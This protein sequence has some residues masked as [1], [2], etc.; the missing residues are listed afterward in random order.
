METQMKIKS[1]EDS[2][3]KLNQMKDIYNS[4]ENLYG[5]FASDMMEEINCQ[6]SFC[7]DCIEN[8]KKITNH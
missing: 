4:E 6:I 8:L 1:Y 3:L 7:I 5:G 2:I